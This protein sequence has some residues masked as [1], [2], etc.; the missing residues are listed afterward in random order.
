MT[1]TVIRSTSRIE[2]VMDCILNQA[3]A[4]TE[5]I[6]TNIQESF[7]S[8]KA[9][10]STLIPPAHCFA[11]KMRSRSHTTHLTVLQLATPRSKNINRVYY[12]QCLLIFVWCCTFLKTI[13]A[14]LTFIGTNKCM[15]LLTIHTQTGKDP[16]LGLG[17][18]PSR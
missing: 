1:L 3:K 5:L 6:H 16:L 2:Y 12:Y 8:W 14:G 7:P 18:I 9:L 4:R 10:G 11:G 15:H 17:H 13:N